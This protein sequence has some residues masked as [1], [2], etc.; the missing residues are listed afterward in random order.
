MNAF[1]LYTSSFTL[2]FKKY[3]E[4]ISLENFYEDIL[5]LKGFFTSFYYL[6]EKL[7]EY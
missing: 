2:F 7:R 6:C 3:E 4:P 5:E 1:A